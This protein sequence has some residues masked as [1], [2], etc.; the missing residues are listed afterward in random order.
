L[1]SSSKP[2]LDAILIVDSDILSRHALAGYLR[3]CGY[4][5][6]ESANTDEALLALAEPALSIDAILCDV[7]TLGTRSGF[8]LAGW[9]RKNRPELEVKLAGSFDRAA[10]A[11]MELCESGPHL[12]RPYDQQAVVDYVKRLRASRDRQRA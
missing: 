11:A 1:T 9:V 2:E 6:V 10:D 5:V 8:E 7:G 3:H 12:G 4:V